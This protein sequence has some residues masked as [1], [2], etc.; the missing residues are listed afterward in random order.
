M[1]AF[2]STP[3]ISILLSAT[4]ATTPVWAQGPFSGGPSADPDALQIRLL[5][6]DSLQATLHSAAKEGLS[7]AVSDPSGTAVPNAAVICRLPDS[8]ATGMFPN[9]T[10][11]VLTYTD[12][13]GHATLNTIEW[14]DVPGDVPIRLTA[15][16]GAAHTGILL[17]TTL[18]ASTVVQVAPAVPA[19]LQPGQLAKPADSPDGSARVTIT[20]A[21]DKPLASTP[22]PT[23]D[24]TVSVTRTP[25]A[26]APHSSHSKWY[27]L[28]GVAAAAGAGAAFSMKGKAAATTPTT[29]PLSIGAPTISIGHP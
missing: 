14:G 7:V 1:Q 22:S 18:V 29:S 8:G 5:N 4:L 23:A 17:E 27:V 3:V 20:P 25:K 19:Q 13:E 16:K 12:A 10:H 24:S 2:L 26:D 15:A 21:S 9:G 28:L 6:P 11:S